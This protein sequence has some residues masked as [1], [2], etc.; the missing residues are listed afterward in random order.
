MQHP[1]LSD[2]QGRILGSLLEKQRTTPDQ[3]PLSLNAL[4]TA[5]NQSTSREPVMHLAEHEVESALT[6]MKS[7]GMVRMVHPSHGRSVTRYRQ[8]YDELQALDPPT[9]SVLAVLLLRG[10]Q[11]SAELRTRTERLHAFGSLADVERCLSE[12]ASA[13]FVQLLERLPGHKEQRWQQLIADEPEFVPPT[14]SSAA[15]REPASPGLADKVAE[16]EA[17]I[18]RLEAALADLL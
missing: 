8:V 6:S 16:L 7:A 17:R 18:E 4:V 11:T 13:G 10:P 5:C 9:C 14:T 1:R 12:A 3:Y 15:R 2:V